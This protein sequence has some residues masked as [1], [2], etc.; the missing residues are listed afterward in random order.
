MEYFIRIKII[1]K[2]IELKHNK[3]DIIYP[4][5]MR[6]RNTFYHT[7]PFKDARG[8]FSSPLYPFLF[9]FIS[10]FLLLNRLIKI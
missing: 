8:S 4:V 5:M 9:F 3:K 2:K 1:K 6:F 7:Y 10:L